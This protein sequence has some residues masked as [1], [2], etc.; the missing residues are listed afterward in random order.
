MTEKRLSNGCFRK[1]EDAIVR[2][3]FKYKGHASARRMSSEIGVARRTFYH[4][5]KAVAYVI[6]DYEEYIYK[7]YCKVVL[8]YLKNS[9]MTVKGLYERTLIFILRER[10]V[11]KILVRAKDKEIF[12]RMVFRL[13]DCMDELNGLHGNTKGI[14][15]IYS[16]EIAEIIFLWGKEGF[17]EGRMEGVLDDIVQVT[18]AM[19]VNLTKLNVY[20]VGS[21]R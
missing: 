3:Y 17:P 5:H 14:Y 2:A 6:P 18:L 11:F 4:H 16:G 8:R 9:K 19:R 13:K 15:E 1:I 21:A 12:S 7:R 10:K 20:R